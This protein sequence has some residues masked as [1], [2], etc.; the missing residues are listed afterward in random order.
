MMRANGRENS[1]V[2]LRTMADHSDGI[3]KRENEWE[4]ICGGKRCVL[5]LMCLV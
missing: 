5:F 2:R 3:H 1:Q 4:V